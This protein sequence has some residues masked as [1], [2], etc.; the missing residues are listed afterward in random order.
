MLNR[1]T[2]TEEKHVDDIL[3]QYI[4]PF[5]PYTGDSLLLIDNT[6]PHTAVVVL[7]YLEEVHPCEKS[8]LESHRTCL[9]YVRAQALAPLTFK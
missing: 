6:R 2:L 1:E 4:V 9:R 5:V 7:L 3:Y 8:E